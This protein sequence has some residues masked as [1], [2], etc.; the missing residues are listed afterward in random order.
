MS[1]SS[2]IQ[3]TINNVFNALDIEFEENKIDY[4]DFDEYKD[5]FIQEQTNTNEYSY[6]EYFSNG[7][8]EDEIMENYHKVIEFVN[9]SHNNMMGENI[10]IEIVLNPH[11]L[12]MNFLYFIGRDWLIEKEE[13][14]IWWE[15]KWEVK[16]ESDDEFEAEL[17]H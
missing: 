4:D 11:K 9:E 1:S 10:D 3:D 8:I 5:E 13:D 16:E 12:K 6:E 14:K 2:F 7:F 15:D 17:K